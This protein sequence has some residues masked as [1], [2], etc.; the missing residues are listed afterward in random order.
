MIAATHDALDQAFEALERETP[1]PLT[2]LICRL[3]QPR[4]RWV[5]IPLGLFFILCACFWF[6]PVV[7]VEFAPIGLLLIAQ[8]VPFLREPVGR[9]MLWLLHRWIRLRQRF[10]GKR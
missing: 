9:M 6:L 1:D 10:Q 2:R 7:G 5:R 4:A 3:R 8:D